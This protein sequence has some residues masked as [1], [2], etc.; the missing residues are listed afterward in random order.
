VTP[1]AAIR[2][3]T[4]RFASAR[5]NAVRSSGVMFFVGAGDGV[6]AGRLCG[7]SGTGGAVLRGRS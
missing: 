2:A 5:A 4:R 1:S 7:K 6:G 3:S